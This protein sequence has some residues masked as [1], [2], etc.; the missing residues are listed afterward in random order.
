M[1][2]HGLPSSEFMDRLLE[3]FKL[4]KKNLKSKRVK[5]CAKCPFEKI[6]TYFFPELEEL[7]ER[8]REGLK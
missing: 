7:F 1:I 8:K 6:I 5:C 4:C 3:H 2:S